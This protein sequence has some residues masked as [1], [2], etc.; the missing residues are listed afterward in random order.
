MSTLKSLPLVLLFA[1][2]LPVTQAAASPSEMLAAGRVDDVIA[3]MQAKI[4]QTPSDSAAYN[5]LCRAYLSVQN[6]DEA[7]S[8]CEKAV[9]LDPR[10]SDYHL[11][12]GRAYGDKADRVGPFAAASLARKLRKQFETAVQLNPLNVDAR[13]DLAEFYTEAPAILGGGDNKVRG[14]ASALAGFAPAKAHYVLGRLAEKQKDVATAEKEYRVAIASS[15][16]NAQD[17]LNLAVFYKHQSRWN[18]MEEAFKKVSTAPAGKSDAL[19]ESADLLLRSGRNPA[20]AAELVRQYLASDA[21]SERFPFFQAHYVLGKALEKQGDI[22][23][24]AREYREALTLASNFP[25][26]KEA[27]GRITQ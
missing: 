10:N 12:L 1:I 17:W 25:P 11:W 21:P 19:L 13:V 2:F 22:Q 4:G 26:A 14:E 5:Y 8:A 18:D 9:S 16:G 20:L 27:L 23:G 3:S 15:G 7:I 6:W 24:A